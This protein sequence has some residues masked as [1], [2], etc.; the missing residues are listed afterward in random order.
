MQM[1]VETSALVDA[2]ALLGSHADT[3][4]DQSRQCGRIAEGRR[5]PSLAHGGR[6]LADVAADLLEVV[7]MDLDLLAGRV[8]SGAVVYDRTEIAVRRSAGG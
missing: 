8:Q 1:R 4:R 7:A 6:L 3:L 5:D 2:S